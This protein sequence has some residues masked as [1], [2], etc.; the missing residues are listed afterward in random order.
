[1]NDVAELEQNNINIDA[2]DGVSDFENPASLEDIMGENG[3]GAGSASDSETIAALAA[4][5]A[6]RAELHRQYDNNPNNEE[7]SQTLAQLDDS[8]ADLEASFMNNG[9]TGV[10]PA[11]AVQAL[12]DA[13]QVGGHAVIESDELDERNQKAIMKKQA[14]FAA[15]VLAQSSSP[16]LPLV[17]SFMDREEAFDNAYANMFEGPTSI[18]NVRLEAAHTVLSTNTELAETLSAS[19]EALR[20]SPGPRSVVNEKIAAFDVA[21]EQAL[22]ENPV[23]EDRVAELQ[24]NR[25]T[26]ID[27]STIALQEMNLEDPTT[28]A[29]QA[30]I[31]ETIAENPDLVA[32]LGGEEAA[33]ASLE[34][35]LADTDDLS[36]AL[37]EQE[38]AALEGELADPNTTD[39]RRE[40]IETQL[41]E[42]EL[43]E[44][45]IDNMIVEQENQAIALEADFQQQGVT[46]DV[47]LDPAKDPG[48]D[49][50]GEN[51]D[52][53]QTQN[54]AEG[55]TAEPTANNARE[56]D[57]VGEF[58]KEEIELQ[59]K[60][61]REEAQLRETF[62]ERERPIAATIG[63]DPTAPEQL[64]AI[65]VE[66]EA[67]LFTQEVEQTEKM[68]ELRAKYGLEPIPL[69]T[70]PISTLAATPDEPEL[71]PRMRVD[72]ELLG[73]LLGK[74]PG[75]NEEWL[76]PLPAPDLGAAEPQIWQDG[77][78]FD[79]STFE[80]R[81]SYQEDLISR[82]KTLADELE[83]GTDDKST[84]L[85]KYE[86]DNAEQKEALQ[87]S[88]QQLL[89]AKLDS[90]PE[91]QHEGDITAAAQEV[92]AML[93]PVENDIE[94]MAANGVL[95]DPVIEAAANK[96][97]PTQ[98][99]GIIT[100]DIQLA[101][102]DATADLQTSIEQL[103]G[104]D[105]TV[106]ATTAPTVEQEGPGRTA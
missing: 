78:V 21:I 40:E 36:L 35:T 27:N 11:V 6:R 25:E 63:E 82:Q 62:L 70:P 22:A 28:D 9:T 83:S 61:I 44:S 73:P 47:I 67:A 42:N 102:T 76:G 74:E 69:P 49:E 54:N 57:V 23:D 77:Y 92:N 72:P 30:L 88:I 98:Q 33:R 55:L 64:Y 43:M 20:T 24:A 68:N 71:T 66:R 19:D 48:M 81:I 5:E 31:D 37:N 16:E 65:D 7:L 103:I 12:A 60:H 91:T 26:F 89:A 94:V 1:M 93:Q 99:T 58:D 50:M 95:Y 51:L 100:D 97:L 3:D 75:E 4:L 15:F 32:A 2:W 85:S 13:S 87:N 56:E 101:A 59:S 104:G 53:Q 90:T 84:L 10:D 8:I 106:P 14:Y 96:S 38:V 18:Q 39:A 79:P 29:A 52:A 17:Y 41:A 86:Q 45:H 105:K 34:E 46:P 80:A